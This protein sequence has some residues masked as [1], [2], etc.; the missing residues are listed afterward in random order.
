MYREIKITVTPEKRPLGG[1][2]GTPSP[3][4][5][6]L[7]NDASLTELP[8]TPTKRSG[9]LPTLA[10]SA[11]VYTPKLPLAGPGSGPST[12]AQHNATDGAKR[13]SPMQLEFDLKD[14]LSPKGLTGA[15]KSPPTSPTRKK[16]V[17]NNDKN[18]AA[19]T[20]PR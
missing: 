2:V 16:P 18:M 13:I 17:P 4:R 12:R 7:S 19:T 9:L 20:F 6:K 8:L 15:L 10:E 14:C 11:A 5:R 1:L 3:K